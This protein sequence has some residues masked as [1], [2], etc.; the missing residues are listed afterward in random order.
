MS[1]VCPLLPRM[2]EK[3]TPMVHSRELLT[4]ASGSSLA[5][6]Q[7]VSVNFPITM[8]AV[9]Q[10]VIRVDLAALAG[11]AVFKRYVDHVAV[12]LIEY[13]E[14]RYGQQTLQRIVPDDIVTHVNM[15]YSDEDRATFHD[16]TGGGLTPAERSARAG[17]VQSVYLPLVNLLRLDER[18]FPDG[19]ICQRGHSEPYK[20]FI[21][22][23]TADKFIEASSVAAAD[24][25]ANAIDYTSTSAFNATLFGSSSGIYAH[26]YTVDDD[27]AKALE[28]SA[29][30]E[31][32]YIFNEY[33]GNTNSTNIASTTTLT[34]ASRVN[35][36]LREFGIPVKMLTGHFRWQ[37]D[38][39]RVPGG[40]SGTYGP[41][42]GN[43]AA[44]YRPG[45][46][47]TPIITSIAVKAGAN[48]YLQ[49]PESPEYLLKAERRR[50]MKGS[51]TSR[52]AIVPIAFSQDVWA[53]NAIFSFV[54]FGQSD[55]ISVD[56]VLSHGTYA[57]LAAAAT[58]DIGASSA[59]NAQFQPIVHNSLQLGNNAAK[60][61][62]TF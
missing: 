25:T 30:I 10:M 53:D 37:V 6:G 18:N 44:W 20:L 32:R 40:A 34:T 52:A 15:M 19:A 31:R 49:D 61:S 27:T 9:R 56:L 41:S 33:A 50:V 38:L 3:A 60:K 5:A 57:D 42:Y 14:L 17:A 59:L 21:K 58:A 51:S 23:A 39:E 2:H 16:H 22:F 1:R 47:A 62:W 28:A 36:G 54:D 7:T 45:G 13:A 35:I 55:N 12:R 43:Y 46:S 11:A 26:G 29:K 8:D 24:V 4:L 48:I